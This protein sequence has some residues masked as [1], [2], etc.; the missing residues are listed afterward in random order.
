[1]SRISRCLGSN[2]LLLLTFL[3]VVLGAGLGIGLRPLLLAPSSIL[4]LSYPGEL[5]MRLLKLMILPLVIAS[6]ITGAASL[7]ARLNGRMAGRTILYFLATSLLSST[8]GLLFTLAVQ[9]GNPRV[10]ELL[11]EGTT[12]ERRVE[13]VDNF[14]DLGRNLVP[15][16]IFQ[17]ALQS[18]I[19][20]YEEMETGNN[21][22]NTETVIKSVTY[23]PG[24]NTLGV[25]FF[26]LAF[27][28]VLGSLGP[29]GRPLVNLF[30]I[31]DQVIMRMVLLIMWV[32]PVGIA[33]VI[34]AKIL[35][36]ADMVI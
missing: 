28:T 1:M 27:G 34:A 29:T 3:G 22:N 6:L 13:L 36:V 16:N 2:L 14:L 11:G 20:S 30:S 31:I 24:T 19:T 25:I 26:C 10:K 4:L 15:D 8:I 32:S 12:G 23:R 7:N 17:A 5:F 21:T 9:P 18:A 35:G 33:S